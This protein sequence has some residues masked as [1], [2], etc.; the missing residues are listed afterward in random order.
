MFLHSFANTTTDL[1]LPFLGITARE[2]VASNHAA[3]VN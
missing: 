2:G 1:I 3:Q